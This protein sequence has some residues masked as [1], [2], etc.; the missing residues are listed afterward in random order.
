MKSRSSVDTYI[1]A[2]EYT[3]P[4]PGVV[5][6]IVL[7][8]V[9]AG[10]SLGTD[11]TKTVAVLSLLTLSTLAMWRPE[12]ALAVFM[13]AMTLVAS[14]WA[15]IGLQGVGQLAASMI[16]VIGFATY[17]GRHGFRIRWKTLPLLVLAFSAIIVI[18]LARTPAPDVGIRRAENYILINMVIFGVALF[19]HD[20]NILWK[21]LWGIFG[22]GLF[23]A[24]VSA[25]DIMF[26]LGVQNARYAVAQFN[27]IWYSRGL[28]LTMIILL[29][30]TTDSKKPTTQVA[31]WAVFALLLYLM[32][33]AASR[34]PLMATVITVAVYI[35]WI[36]GKRK[37][38]FRILRVATFVLL[39]AF[40]YDVLPRPE[41]TSR[42]TVI[43]ESYSDISS[44]HRIQAYFTSVDLF[45]KNP[46]MG[47]GTG[48]FSAYNYL[49]YPH[50]IEAEIA[51]EYGLIGIALAVAILFAVVS[52]CKR[53]GRR[54]TRRPREQRMYRCFILITIYA[55]A[56]AQVSGPITGNSWIWLGIGG[57]W[58]IGT[59][60]DDEPD[61]GIAKP[62]RA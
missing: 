26:I 62:V 1:L 7:I 57:I 14:T 58:A 15:S 45:L 48:G 54:L 19:N 46:L 42:L 47:V 31:K 5:A 20:H 52:E 24:L 53:L 4:T 44:L 59:L 34:G 17:I 13:S 3:R 51:S 55:I 21:L 37:G 61:D 10:T 40:A 2:D 16:V 60:V 30:L 6:V 18:G 33:C 12:L 43:S 29:A 50:N 35:F 23:M 39:I 56:N 28:G 49:R 41:I 11:P 9:I 22:F 32:I 27:P 38:P 36:P 25:V 8:T